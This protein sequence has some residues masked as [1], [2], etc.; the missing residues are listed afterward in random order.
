MKICE[1]VKY[2]FQ[3]KQL[4]VFFFKE[5]IL[6]KILDLLPPPPP[7]S[8]LVY[9]PTSLLLL[10]LLFI[11]IGRVR[12]GDRVRCGDVKTIFYSC[13]AMFFSLSYI[14]LKNNRILM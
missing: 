13:R 9:I 14:S 6:L 1:N 8:T 7:C 4:F 5:K 12:E 2:T 10:L 11:P 3:I